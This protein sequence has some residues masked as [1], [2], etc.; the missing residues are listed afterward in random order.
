MPYL[1]Q[2]HKRSNSESG[3]AAYKKMLGWNIDQRKDDRIDNALFSQESIIICSILVDHRK[4]SHI[5]RST[6]TIIIFV[7]LPQHKPTL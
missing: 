1:E 3:F 5:H 6:N 2:Y 4:V 7:S